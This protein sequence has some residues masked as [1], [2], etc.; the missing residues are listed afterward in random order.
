MRDALR[1]PLVATMSLVAMVALAYAV[2]LGVGTPPNDWDSVIYHLPRAALWYQQG[3]VGYVEGTSDERIDVAPPHA[4]IGILFTMLLS[5]SDRWM[6]LVQTTSLL[7][8]ATTVFALGRRVGLDLR[9]ALFGALVFLCLPLLL[10]Q[11]GT[12]LN[13]IV[14][15]A[16]LAA[17]VLFALAPGR[18]DFCCRVWRSRSL[19]ARRRRPSSRSPRPSSSYCGCCRGNAGSLSPAPGL[20][21]SQPARTGTTSTSPVPVAS[22]GISPRSSNKSLIDSRSPCCCASTSCRST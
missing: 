19:R 8:L 21:V 20:P 13:D 2:A 16:F 14:V 1:D 22:T 12:A 3:H 9:Q 7:A 17:A 5:R 4:E 6:S 18:P 10:L 11:A 15:A